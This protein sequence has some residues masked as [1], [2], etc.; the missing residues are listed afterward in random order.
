MEFA[1]TKDRGKDVIIMSIEDFLCISHAA[2]HAS[3]DVE[4]I[5]QFPITAHQIVEISRKIESTRN[6]IEKLNTEKFPDVPSQEE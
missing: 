5:K 1:Y 6:I 4:Y 2:L 3:S